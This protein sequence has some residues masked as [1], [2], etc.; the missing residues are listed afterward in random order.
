MKR[1][2]RRS[3]TAPPRIV[4]DTNV[5]LSALVFDGGAIASLRLG[6]QRGNCLPL[7]SAATVQELLRVLA[8]P[9]FR[10]SVD[11]QEELLADCLPYSQTVRIPEPPP[12][13]PE[14]RD[15]FDAPF[16]HLA[17]VGHADFLV[18]G[19]KDLLTLN[20]ALQFS[21]L[22]PAEFLATLVTPE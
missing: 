14:C 7:V 21:V 2:V 4:L 20:T 10:L 3:S 16:L 5:V 6:W 19:D 22:R 13:V 8:Y 12:T 15:Q 17:I 1:I 11:E 18:S 9:K